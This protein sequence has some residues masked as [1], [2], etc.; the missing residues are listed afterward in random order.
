MYG[1]AFDGVSI[2]V[3][4]PVGAVVEL[5]VSDGSILGTFPLYGEPVGVAFDGANIWVTVL[6]NDS[7]SKM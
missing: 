4:A 5:R 1:V 3:A 7:V 2:W 6:D